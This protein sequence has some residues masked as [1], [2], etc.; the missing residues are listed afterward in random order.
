MGN[1]CPFPAFKYTYL[2]PAAICW[3]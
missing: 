3:S 1:E 2:P